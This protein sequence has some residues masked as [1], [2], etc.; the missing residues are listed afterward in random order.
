[1]L[2]MVL[3]MALELVSKSIFHSFNAM[4]VLNHFL[5]NHKV[6]LYVISLL[7]VFLLGIACTI[8]AR[9]WVHFYI[10]INEAA[11]MSQIN[12]NDSNSEQKAKRYHIH[13]KRMHFILK[14]TIV[15]IFSV[16]SIILGT[17]TYLNY[18]YPKLKSNKMG[19]I[20]TS[21]GFA[22]LGFTFS[23]YG[24][25]ILF[26]LNMAFFDFYVVNRN[27]L[28]FATLGLSIPMIM[29]SLCD[30]LIVFS[31]C[32]HKL[33]DDNVDVWNFIDLFVFDIIPISF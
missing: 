12:I 18:K 14:V 28:I 22:L 16:I 20:I 7:P 23:F 24:L 8:N 26:K 9:N 31:P 4:T 17:T 29:R 11:Y 6:F 3:F 25:K 1:M 27:K 30:L 21:I 13:T 15:T 2:V 19:R 10:R 5:F 33:V 32:F